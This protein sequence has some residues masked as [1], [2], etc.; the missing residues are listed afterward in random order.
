MDRAWIFLFLSSWNGIRGHLVFVLS[1][2]LSVCLSMTL[3]LCCK[4]T[5]TLAITFDPFE[6]HIPYEEAFPS[7]PKLWP[8]YLD[9]DL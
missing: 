2:T 6:M 7:I 4:K 3:S 9:R 5:L 8:S 1:V